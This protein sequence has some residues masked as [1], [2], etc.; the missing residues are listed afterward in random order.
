MKLTYYSIKLT[1]Y[2][3]QNS[4]TITILLHRQHV[5]LKHHV[6]PVTYK[7]HVSR[8]TC[9]VIVMTL[10]K[11]MS[12]DTRH[13]IHTI[14]GKKVSCDT[15]HATDLQLA[16]FLRVWFWFAAFLSIWM[17][18]W[19]SRFVTLVHCPTV[20]DVTSGSNASRRFFYCLCSAAWVFCQIFRAILLSTFLCL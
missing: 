14:S 2:S 1:Y 7:Y 20:R 11:K 10:E 18:W 19:S 15:C 9:H 16:G 12:R 6:L 4:L 3:F 8:D 5:Y 17:C 13:V